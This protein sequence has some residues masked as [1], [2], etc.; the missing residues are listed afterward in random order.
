MTGPRTQPC[1]DGVKGTLSPCRVEGRSP[2][3]GLGQRPKVYDSFK[4]SVMGMNHWGDAWKYAGRGSGVAIKHKKRGLGRSPTTFK[5]YI[6]GLG[7]SVPKPLCIIFEPSG[8]LR[9]S[10]RLWGFAPD[11]TRGLLA[12]W[13][14]G[15]GQRPLHPGSTRRGA[16]RGTI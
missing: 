15:R 16:W 9:P 12:L 14:P 5:H 11:P 1:S 6:K 10:A 13:T 4:L 8:A 2:S 3:W 7:D